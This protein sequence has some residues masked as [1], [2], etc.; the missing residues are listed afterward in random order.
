MIS[1]LLFDFDGTIADTFYL[2]LSI[3]NEIAQHF[4]I[5]QLTQ[6]E[7]VLFRTRP[8]GE[9]IRDLKIPIRK[10]PAILVRIRQELHNRFDQIQPIDGIISIIK[11]LRFKCDRIGIVTSNSEQNANRFLK[12][13]NLDFFNLG[14]VSTKIFGKTAELRKIIHKNHL[15]KNSVLY[16]GDTIG[17]IDS[18]RKAGIKI[19]AVTWGYNSRDVLAASNPDYLISQ[20]RE[21]LGI[22]L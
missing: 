9:I 11:E 2:A 12:K 19:S 16:V 20:P 6:E 7:L 21:L 3:G 13:H 1:T 10:I 14:V 15:D 17:D 8:F 22:L 18:C 5:R 4:G